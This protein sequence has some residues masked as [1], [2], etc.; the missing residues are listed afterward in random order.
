MPD[1][2]TYHSQ[3]IDHLGIVAGLFDEPTSQHMSPRLPLLQRNDEAFGRALE[4]LSTTGVTELYSIL[5][6]TAAERMVL[7]PCW[8]HLDPTSVRGE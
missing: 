2:L 4:T 6:A 7:A 5:A 8:V 3:V 1:Q